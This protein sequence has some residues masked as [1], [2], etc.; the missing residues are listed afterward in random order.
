MPALPE[1]L[2]RKLNKTGQTRGADNDEIF[3]NRVSRASTV[4][5]PD[6]VWFQHFTI[7]KAEALF[8]KGYIILLSPEAYFSPKTQEPRLDK[9]DLVLGK[10]AL[11]FYQTRSQWIAND[12]T[13]LG[14]TPAERRVSPFLGEYVARISGT[15][16]ANEKG[17]PILYGFTT[18]KSK[19]AGIRVYEYASDQ[20]ILN[21]RNQLEALFWLCE[22]S[23]AVA[24]QQGM[25]IEACEERSQKLLDTCNSDSLLNYDLLIENRILNNERKTIC[26]LCLLPLSGQGFFKRMPQAVGREVLDLTITELNLFHIEELRMGETNHKPYN[27]GWGHHHCNVV[28]KDAG[29]LPTIKWMT[30]V[31]KRNAL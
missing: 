25:L 30:E 12:P 7:K 23:T 16:A 2:Q 9:S 14:W 17:K 4:L 22:D 29:I 27:L 21:C 1:L 24:I 26:P 10:N 3:Q 20:D 5:I 31:V 19:G 15:T 8:K 11:V 13:R 18:T 28:V 6:S